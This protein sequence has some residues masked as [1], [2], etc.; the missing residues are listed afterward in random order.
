MKRGSEEAAG[1]IKPVSPEKKKAKSVAEKQPK[2]GL[3][4]VSG[5][6]PDKKKP[7]GK[8]PQWD[9]PS[10]AQQVGGDTLT[11]PTNMLQSDLYC[12]RPNVS[13]FMCR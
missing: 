7:K 6:S 1:E 12:V 4:K 8:E 10:N 5:Q 9:E 13:I 2:R 11:H 3:E